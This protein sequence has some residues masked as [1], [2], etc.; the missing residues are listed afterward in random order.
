MS[1]VEIFTSPQFALTCTVL[2]IAF[3]I[4]AFRYNKVKQTK[5]FILT[6]LLVNSMQ[7]L[8]LFA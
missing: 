8:L 1:I 5:H 6:Y 7:W 4:F 3:I 2:T